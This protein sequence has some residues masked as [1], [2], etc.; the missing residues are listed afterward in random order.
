MLFLLNDVVLTIDPGEAT[1]PLGA[2]KFARLSLD[3]LSALGAE[4]F[5][6]DPALARNNPVRAAR[7]ASLIVMK[8]PEINAALFVAPAKGCRPEQVACRY[9]SLT[10]DILA[11]LNLRQQSGILTATDADNAVWR[12]L[13]A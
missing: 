3:K 1:P 11:G 2:E 4:L 13:A 9:A 10:L 6:G 12:R 5:T 7:L 8:S